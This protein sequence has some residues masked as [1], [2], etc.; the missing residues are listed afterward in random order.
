[1]KGDVMKDRKKVWLSITGIVNDMENSDKDTMQFLTE[2]DMYRESNASCFTYLETAV[3]GMEGTTTTV[4]VEPKKVSVIRL[5]TVN[6]IMEF[7][8]G[9]KNVTQ[10]NTPYGSINMGV[11]TR[12]IDIR[13]ND[14]D[15]P[16]K[17]NVQYDIKLEGYT[18]SENTLQI[19]VKDYQ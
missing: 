15:E 10:V 19:E 14:I 4:M 2:G 13:Y 7:V 16:V 3:S 8:S 18:N 5:G 17:V 6:S 12:D 1:M 9:Q 11:V